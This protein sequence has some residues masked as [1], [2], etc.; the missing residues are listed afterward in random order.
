MGAENKEEWTAQVDRNNAEMY[1]AIGRFVVM[2]EYTCCDI[3]NTVSILLDGTIV[4]AQSPGSSLM[5]LT[6]G[7][8][9]KKLEVL[10]DCTKL[11]GLTREERAKIKTALK[12]FEKLTVFRNELMHNSWYLDFDAIATEAYTPVIGPMGRYTTA[13]IDHNSEE[14]ERLRS[15]FGC[16]AVCHMP[17]EA[18]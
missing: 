12:D 6:A 3:R 1:R 4:A 5:K 14:A 7:P 2:F 9:R 16:L 10:M 8:I 15:I 18:S 13:Q 11:Q 17:V